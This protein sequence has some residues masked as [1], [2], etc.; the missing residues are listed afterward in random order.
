M[1][2]R[3]EGRQEP[4]D[5]GRQNQGQGR[6]DIRERSCVGR[7]HHGATFRFGTRLSW[8]GWGEAKEV[9][10]ARLPLLD[11]SVQY[12]ETWAIVRRSSP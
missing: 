5:E 9:N 10:E 11:S 2:G 7:D 4:G 3:E 1:M 6:L 12:M 8:T